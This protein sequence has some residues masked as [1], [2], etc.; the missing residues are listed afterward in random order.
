[1]L[2]SKTLFKSYWFYISIVIVVSFVI[3]LQGIYAEDK[4]FYDGG[5]KYP[6]YI[7]MS[8]LKPLFIIW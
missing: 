3:T 8:F 5:I 7:I 4:A 1:M 2:Q 6:N